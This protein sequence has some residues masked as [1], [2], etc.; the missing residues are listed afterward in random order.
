M[1]GKSTTATSWP[2]HWLGSTTSKWLAD[3]T[4]AKEKSPMDVVVEAS[5]CPLS[6]PFFSCS[7]CHHPKVLVT[8]ITSN[9]IRVKILARRL[10]WNINVYAEGRVSESKGGFCRCMRLLSV[11][12]NYA[13]S[14]QDRFN[15]QT[16]TRSAIEN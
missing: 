3:N 2:I 9:N 11:A 13:L 5:G 15:L 16:K 7:V 14:L 1:G 4:E 6:V 8:I 12:A 10:D